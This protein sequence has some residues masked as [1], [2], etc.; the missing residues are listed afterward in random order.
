MAAMRTGCFALPLR[1][2]IAS[3]KLERARIAREEPPWND[4][5]ED[6]N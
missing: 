4:R 6:R 1:S 5:G 2:A 3:M